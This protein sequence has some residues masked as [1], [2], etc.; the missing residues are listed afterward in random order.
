MAKPHF[1]IAIA[2]VRHDGRWLVAR[3]HPDVHLGGMWEF[4]GGKMEPGESLAAAAQRE[5]LEECDVHATVESIL[6]AL[7]CEYDV[8]TVVLHPVV[9][10]WVSGEAR[11]LG[12][13]E[14]RWVTPEELQKLEMPP[15]N[16]AL[17]AAIRGVEESSGI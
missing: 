3:R 16:A 5:L 15:I 14:C 4:P 9:C 17:V 6:D 8:R 7:Y 1:D 13:A 11:P 2:L 12:S 10:R